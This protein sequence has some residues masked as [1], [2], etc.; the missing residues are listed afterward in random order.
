MRMHGRAAEYSCFII[1]GLGH[2]KLPLPTG[3]SQ[4]RVFKVRQPL[5]SLPRTRTRMVIVRL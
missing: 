3:V 1:Q 4:R 2:V 5:S